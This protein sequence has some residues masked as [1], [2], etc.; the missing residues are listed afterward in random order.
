MT[1]NQLLKI[2]R[3]K[4][5]D[6]CGGSRIEADECEI[7][8]CPL[9]EYRSGE[10]IDKRTLRSKKKNEKSNDFPTNEK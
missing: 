8:T 4:C 3:S 5:L 1:V 7:I 6:C 2:I 10:W 9:H